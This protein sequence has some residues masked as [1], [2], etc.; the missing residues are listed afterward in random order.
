MPRQFNIAGQTMVQIV[1]PAG[2]LFAGTFAWNGSATGVLGGG[3][4]LGLSVKPIEVT[5]D[6]ISDP[7]IVNAYGPD[8]P[9]DEQVFGGTGMLR[10]ELVHFD[11]VMLGEVVRLSR[12]ANPTGAAL[13]ATEGTLNTAGSLRGNNSLLGSATNSLMT[14]S[15]T[16]PVGNFLPYTFHAC[17]LRE[18]PI[19][20]P[21]GAERTIVQLTWN[22]LAYTI[23]PWNA[24]AGS[25]GIPIYSR[26]GSNFAP[27][28]PT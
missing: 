4:Q 28:N 22:A 2:S 27:P 21:L 18:R 23:D 9:I 20:F 3:A 8:N 24:G 6:I 10:M 1:G 5:I 12:G 7:V 16:S 17:Y 19:V 11:P 15:L 14:V 26:V 13:A 25:L